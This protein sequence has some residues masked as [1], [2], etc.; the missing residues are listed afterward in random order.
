MTYFTSQIDKNSELA[1]QYQGKYFAK[2]S[3]SPTL[4]EL[5]A[6]HPLTAKMYSNLKKYFFPDVD[7][8]W[9]PILVVAKS[10]AFD[11]IYG[12]V[13]CNQDGKLTLSAGMVNTVLEVD[14]KGI[15]KNLPEDIEGEL[16]ITSAEFNGYKD[17][18]IAV[19]TLT[20]GDTTLI[21]NLSLKTRKLKED[22]KL[23]TATELNTKLKRD[24]AGL[25][26]W[27]GGPPQKQMPTIPAKQLPP[28]E[29]TVVGY[30][31]LQTKEGRPLSILEVSGAIS[32]EGLFTQEYI[33]PDDESRETYLPLEM[34]GVFAPYDIIGLLELEPGI[35]EEYPATLQIRSVTPGKKAGT[36]RVD[37]GFVMAPNTPMPTVEV[38][39]LSILDF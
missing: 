25:L 27:L 10:G 31:N 15:I 22:E 26:S 19:L 38:E 6:V 5:Q 33:D 20:K 1:T 18:S 23:P 14:K 30:R 8:D 17:T 39:D 3:N 12:P 4:E 28:G 37:S 7:S 35:S 21:Y 13:I 16:I 11:K 36:F 29:Y 24:Q 34:I 2:N 9:S 32:E